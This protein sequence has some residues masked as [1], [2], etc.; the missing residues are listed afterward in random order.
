MKRICSSFESCKEPRRTVIEK[1]GYV[2][3]ECMHCT[4]RYCEIKDDGNHLEKVYGDDYFFEGKQGYPNYLNQKDILLGY[5][6]KYAKALSKYTKPGKLLDVG[7]AAGFI[8]KGFSDAGW[9]CC[10]LEPNNTMAE[11]GRKELGLNIITGGL[12]TFATN[13]KFD[14]VSIIQVIGHFINL[15][16]AIENIGKLLK[17]NGLVLIESW[18]RSSLMA[19]MMGKNWHEYS[20]PSVINWFND[21]TLTQLLVYYGFELLAKGRPSK[22]ISIQHGLSL[23]DESMPSFFLKKRMLNFFR[24]TIGRY[25]IPYPPFDVKWYVFK[26]L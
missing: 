14:V 3:V 11:Y 13:E 2:I 26:R 15:D 19:R 5:G 16:H 9:Q 12:E 25:D 17:P 24:K 20:P 22:R 21:K 8:L 23:F 6:R 10:G 7:S 1:G 18:D 4:H